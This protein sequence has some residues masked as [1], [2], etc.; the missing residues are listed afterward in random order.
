M[1]N[2][3]SAQKQRYRVPAL[4]QGLSV[5]ELFTKHTPRLTAAEVARH[6]SLPKATTYRLLGTLEDTRYLQRCEDDRY[7]QLGPALLNRGF[8]YLATLDVV[9]IAA[10]VLRNL[11]DKSGMSS[12]MAVRDGTR[13]VYVS[14]FPASNTIQGSVQVGTHF[15]LHATVMGRMLS[16]DLTQEELRLLYPQ[17]SLPAFTPHTPRTVEKFFELLQADKKLNYAISESFFESGVHAV[18]APIRNAEGQI[19]AAINVTDVR[20]YVETDHL[21]G[22][23]KDL[24]LEA[25]LEIEQWLPKDTGNQRFSTLKPL[26]DSSHSVK[27]AEDAA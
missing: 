25:V 11:R 4:V 22:Q 19:V 20:A 3:E 15:P 18:A 24:V 27:K 5:L 6:L 7:Y 17:E 8:E 23:I 12:H 1:T 2:D 14:R 10:P 16:L 21:R 26:P 13:V 9:E